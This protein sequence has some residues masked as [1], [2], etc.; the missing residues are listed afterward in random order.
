MNVSV[1]MEDSVAVLG[2]HLLMCLRVHV[3]MYICIYIYTHTHLNHMYTQKRSVHSCF[4]HGAMPNVYL[5]D[6]KRVINGV[7]W[8][9]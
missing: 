9:V 5:M 1:L 6:V 8:N 2:M 4:I 7:F 3:C